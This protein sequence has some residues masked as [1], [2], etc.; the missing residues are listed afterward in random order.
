MSATNIHGR[1]GAFLCLLFGALN[2]GC[3]KTGEQ[4]P[5]RLQRHVE[6]YCHG[7][8]SDIEHASQKYN[9]IATNLEEMSQD[10]RRR[11]EDV[12]R[13]SSIGADEQAR[14][15]WSIDVQKRLTFCASVRNID[16]KKLDDIFVRTARLSERLGPNLDGV[17]PPYDDASTM[18]D[19]LEAIAKEVD[20]LPLLD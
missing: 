20:V 2:A 15:A 12:L 18:L 6:L 16:T 9:Q 19:E 3:G 14:R 7:T 10:Q 8:A 17:L 5:S 4:E 1:I 13:W 11:A